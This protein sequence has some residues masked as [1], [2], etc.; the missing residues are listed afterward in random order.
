MGGLGKGAVAFALVGVVAGLDTGDL[1]L[2]LGLVL[3]G[4]LVGALMGVF[5]AVLWL[6][7]PARTTYAVEGAD[8]VAHRRGRERVRVPC[9]HVTRLD[10]PEALSWAD[11]SIGRMFSYTPFATP[12][13]WIEVRVPDRWSTD[14]GSHRLPSIL[15]W[16]EQ[17]RANAEHA[18]RE[19]I[20][21]TA[22]SEPQRSPRG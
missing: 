21:A 15:L 8:L 7:G 10:I 20:R 3:A 1:A 9:A 13:A 12:Q 14:N 17:R 4:V 18:L 6:L 19:A 2:A 16:G 5:G 11:V 22:G